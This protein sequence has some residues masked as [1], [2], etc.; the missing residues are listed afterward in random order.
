M[1]DVHV[2]GY[3]HRGVS[4]KMNT[5]HGTRNT[6]RLGR[7]PFRVPC[8]VFRVDRVALQIEGRLRRLA[9]GAYS[10]ILGSLHT[11]TTRRP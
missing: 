7:H 11:P 8:S 4:M 9:L 2:I 10:G 1:L 6:E 5:E 3:L